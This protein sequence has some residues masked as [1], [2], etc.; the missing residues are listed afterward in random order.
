[1]TQYRLTCRTLEIGEGL[2]MV[3]VS[4][5]RIEAPREG[6]FSRQAEC[7]SP[8]EAQWLREILVDQVRTAVEAVGGSVTD[9]RL[10]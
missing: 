5:S 9:I 10:E 1:M 4:A 3:T 8:S 2:Y 6:G 7:R